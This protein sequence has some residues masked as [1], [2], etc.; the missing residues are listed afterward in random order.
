MII[1]GSRTT[2]PRDG[3]GTQIQ[4]RPPS[5]IIIIIS[6]IASK[7][8]ATLIEFQR[9]HRRPWSTPGIPVPSSESPPL[10]GK[11]LNLINFWPTICA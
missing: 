1:P 8:L 11:V 4:G 6:G 9:R 7:Y 5:S 3:E 2:H 10:V